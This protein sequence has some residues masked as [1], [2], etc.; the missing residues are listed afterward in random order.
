MITATMPDDEA[1]TAPS[2][3]P[4]RATPADPYAMLHPSVHPGAAELLTSGA[5]RRSAGTADRM[6]PPPRAGADQARQYPSRIGNH[7]HWPDG[8]VTGMDG[9]E[10]AA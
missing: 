3:R 10:S 9:E 1:D 5:V 7:L 6:P 4:I 8:R 2:G